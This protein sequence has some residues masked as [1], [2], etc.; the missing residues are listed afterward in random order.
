MATV[1]VTFT[2]DDATIAMLNQAAGR[3]SK[4][5]S[6]VVRDAIADYHAKSDRLG[7]AERL[8]LLRV[9]DEMMARPDSRGN[10]ETDRELRQIREGR[11]W[12][13]R[14]EVRGTR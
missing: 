3:L 11:R 9:L 8:R 1:K 6:E 10:Q 5:K 14:T 7:D 2:L 13:R 4:T 12:G